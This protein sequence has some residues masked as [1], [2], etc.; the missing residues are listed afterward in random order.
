[1][2]TFY[3]VT[4]LDCICVTSVGEFNQHL[5]KIVQGCTDVREVVAE[6]QRLEPYVAIIGEET[7]EAYLVVDKHII[8]KFSIIDIPFALMAAFFVYNICYPKG[9][10]NFYTF[11]E[12]VVLKFSLEK[13]SPSVKYLLAK[14]N[15]H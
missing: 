10:N 1:M 6:N 2:I 11:L 5:L 3:N 8:D 15:A 13:A 4:Q 14:I 9:C 12:I 7:V